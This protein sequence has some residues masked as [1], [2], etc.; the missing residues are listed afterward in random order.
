MSIR[1]CLFQGITNYSQESELGDITFPY[2]VQVLKT[3]SRILWIPRNIK[4]KNLAFF[5][6]NE[7]WVFYILMKM[8]VIFYDNYLS[9][10]HSSTFLL[11]IFPENTICLQTNIPK[12]LFVTKIVKQKKKHI[13]EESNTKSRCSVL[14]T[15]LLF[16]YNGTSTKSSKMLQRY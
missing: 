1:L 3:H 6:H 10:L 12:Y 5:P 14:K 7:I 16:N 8:K 9:R 15:D 13:M 4:Y 2:F 11:F